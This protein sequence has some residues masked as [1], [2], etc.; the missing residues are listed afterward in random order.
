MA[1]AHQLEILN[2]GVQVWNNWR[3]QNP[4]QLV[5]LSQADLQG[6]DLVQINLSNAQ[7]SG[8]RLNA[9][10][11]AQADLHHADL[12]RANLS[13]ADLTNVD[14]R[15]AVLTTASMFRVDL[16]AARLDSANLVGSFLIMAS[17]EMASLQDADLAAC[18]LMNVNFAKANLTRTVFSGARMESTVFADTSLELARGL[19]TVVHSGPSTIGIDT[20]YRS[21]GRIA[22]VFL[23][24]AGVPD[25]VITLARS[26]AGQRSLFNSCFISYSTADEEFATRLHR[27][28]QAN[29]VRCWFAPHDVRGGRKIHQQIEDA[30][31]SHDRLLLVLS[32]TSMRS[33]WV[34][35]EL[36]T[37]R[38]REASERKRV[39]FPIRLVPFDNVR[40]WTSVDPDTGKDAARDVREYFIPDFTNWK[41]PEHYEIGLQ[42]LL[43]DLKAEID[44][45]AK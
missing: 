29:G 5:D 37:A 40:R 22:E 25:D 41:I 12:S 15:R 10:V 33:D 4:S 13:G 11:L 17:L 21:N 20:L 32:E 18:Y 9:A 14:L 19:E 1:T 39:L 8:A 3:Q 24:G 30:I 44:D 45:L 38:R 43:R 27:D 2:E 28:L 16:T 34:N 23:R 42:N 6:R 26:L 31:R 36:S 35:N 7:L